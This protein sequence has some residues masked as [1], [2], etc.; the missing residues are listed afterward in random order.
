MKTKDQQDTIIPS[1]GK[2]NKLFDPANER[3]D[4]S[5][6]LTALTSA[7]NRGLSQ[8]LGGIDSFKGATSYSLGTTNADPHDT[9]KYN[10]GAPDEKKTIDD[11]KT[12]KRNPMGDGAKFAKGVRSSRKNSSFGRGMPYSGMPRGGNLLGGRFTSSVVA[13]IGS[14]GARHFIPT[15]GLF[16]FGVNGGPRLLQGLNFEGAWPII[17]YETFTAGRSATPTD[18]EDSED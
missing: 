4:S 12:P 18:L 14:K 3:P 1:N 6:A 17:S 11:Y 7:T 9:K 16:D 15:Q 2:A 10:L 13:A 5:F 8:H